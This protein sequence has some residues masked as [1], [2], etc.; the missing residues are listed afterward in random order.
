MVGRGLQLREMLVGLGF[1]LLDT[2]TIFLF[3]VPLF[4]QLVVPL[5]C[6]LSI[7][8][9]FLRLST[10]RE[11]VALKAGGISIYQLLPAPL[12]F[13][14]LCAE[15][16]LYVSVFGV[17]WGMNNF[18]S[19]ILEVASSR[20]KVNVQP[21][22]FNQ[23]I[24]GLT[25]FARKVD[26]GTGRMRQ[27]I[28]E[29]KT[30][31]KSNSITILASRGEILTDEVR[32]ELLFHLSDGRIYRLDKG[33]LSVLSFD[34]YTVRLDL[35]KIFSGVDLG[36]LRPKEMAW[37]D[38]RAQYAAGPKKGDIKAFRKVG[39]ELN[40]RMALPMACMVLGLFALPLACTFEGVKRQIG[41][42]VSLLM[43]LVYYALFSGGVTLAESGLLPTGIAIWAPNLVFLILAWLGIYYTVRERNPDWLV[44]LGRIPSL[45][46]SRGK[47]A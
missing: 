40:K 20:A 22:V 45:R 28:F 2:A 19:T 36:S 26:P 5:A 11:L 46:P 14:A 34:E 35:A 18:R 42:V 29:D 43:F 6:M 27:V 21:G 1:G 17:S 13:S 30:R 12:V 24:F 47:K 8:L 32:G 16:T 37:K 7:F 33:Q 10:D 38:L 44:F 4:L 23:D 39:I 41:V 9:T 15:L 31:D 25:L 3:L